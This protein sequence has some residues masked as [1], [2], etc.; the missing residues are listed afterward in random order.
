[1]GRLPLAFAAKAQAV[2]L[3]VVCVGLR[4]EA[5][6]AL[7]GLVTRFH[8]SSPGRLGRVIRLFRRAGGRRAVMAGEV[9]KANSLHKPWKAPTP[10]PDWRTVCW[11][12]FR[13]RTDNKDD[14]LLLSLVDE[15][16][17]DGI[18]FASA[19]DLCPELLVKAGVLT[20]RRTTAPEEADIAFGWE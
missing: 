19:L 16:A 18:H 4:G 12:Y 14:T 1:Y 7:A 15:F 13:R 9:H 11:W 8:W 5:D 20:R 6:P 2:G 17:R 3:P 10:G